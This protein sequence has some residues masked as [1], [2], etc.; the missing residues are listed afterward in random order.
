MC[1]RLLLSNLYDNG[2]AMGI[3]QLERL[4]PPPPPQV[5]CV[6]PTPM[7]QHGCKKYFFP[8]ELERLYSTLIPLMSQHGVKN[9]FSLKSLRD[10]ILL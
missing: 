10:F 5:K 3:C 6:G 7:S 9:T 4:C 2:F 1:V 8:Q